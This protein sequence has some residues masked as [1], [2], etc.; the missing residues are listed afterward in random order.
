MFAAWPGLICNGLEA[1][2][3]S[4]LEARCAYV[5]DA[6]GPPDK[7]QVGFIV[8]DSRWVSESTASNFDRCKK[9]VEHS[10]QHN[11]LFD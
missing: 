6:R 10:P 2:R 3:R 11:S 8:K 7:G 1:Y 5:L 9:C 4:A